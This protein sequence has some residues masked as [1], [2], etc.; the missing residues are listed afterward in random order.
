MQPTKFTKFCISFVVILAA[1]LGL[2]AGLG[3]HSTIWGLAVAGLTEL[4]GLGII[5]LLA[6]E[7]K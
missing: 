1:L 3:L 2:F 7:G 4:V 5:L 6:L